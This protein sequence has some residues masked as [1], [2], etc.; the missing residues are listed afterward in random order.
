[1]NLYEILEIN[2]NASEKEIK[3]AYHKLALKYHPDKNKDIDAKEKFQ[4]IQ[5]AYNIL[6]DPKTRIDYCKMNRIQQNN[7]VNLLQKIFKNDLLID[8]IKHFGI[9][10]DKKD[11][12][13]LEKNFTN[14][15]DSLNLKELINFFKNGK[16]PK[17]KIDPVLSDTEDTLTEFNENICESYFYLPVYYQKFNSLDIIL[18]LNITLDDLLNNNK[19]KI[20]IKRTVNDDI[21]YNTFIFNLSK[22][23]IIYQNFGD[24]KNNNYGNLIIKLNLPKNY[25]WSENIVIL[26]KGITLYEMIYGLDVIFQHNDIK[27]KYPKW[28]PVRDGVIIEINQIKSINFNLKLVLNYE[29]SDEKEKILIKYF[30]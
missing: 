8:E 18:N 4:N 2:E 23:Y 5:S 28:V 24:V 7:F 16:F 3:R 13:Y 1:M 17:K 27:I 30:S 14:L 25:L 22:P 11:W 15:F 6:I 21:I 19:R 20:K 12:N 26:E 9:A 29:H 10:F